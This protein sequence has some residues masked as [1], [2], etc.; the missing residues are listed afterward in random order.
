MPRTSLLLMGW[1]LCASCVE[2]E[3]HYAGEAGF[4]YF[5]DLVVAVTLLIQS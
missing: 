1:Q 5:A 3:E 2:E 4:L